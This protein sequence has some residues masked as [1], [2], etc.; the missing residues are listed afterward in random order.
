MDQIAIMQIPQGM[1]YAL[2][3]RLPAIVGKKKYSY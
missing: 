1:A 3:A 2:L